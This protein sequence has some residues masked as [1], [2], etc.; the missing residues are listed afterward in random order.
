MLKKTKWTPIDN[1]DELAPGRRYPSMRASFADRP[2]DEQQRIA[3]YLRSGKD[4]MASLSLP[5]D[6]I[7]GQRMPG[8][9]LMMHD[10][11]YCW[12]SELAYYVEQYNLRLP[13]EIEQHILKKAG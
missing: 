6:V 2:Y 11:D 12:S 5:R 8:T 9:T 7:T 3:A 1:Y 13:S 4:Y 10:S